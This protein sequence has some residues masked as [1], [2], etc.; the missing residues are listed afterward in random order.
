M[1][2]R[3]QALVPLVQGA[4]P[5]VAPGG[6]LARAVNPPPPE[7]VKPKRKLT[8]V[9][10]F[11]PVHGF[12]RHDPSNI[13]RQD[14]RYWVF[15]T[16][17]AGDH[18]DVTIHH[19]DSADGLNWRDLGLALGRGEP[20]QWDESGTIAPC[21]VP[22]AGRF[23]LFYTGFRGGDLATRDIGIAVAGHPS[24]PWRRHAA[25][26]VLRRDPDPAVWDSGMLGDANVLLRG[27]RWWL[28]FKGRRAGEGN[29]QTRVGVAS[30]DSPLGPFRR[31]PAN[32]LFPGH[33]FSAWV[34][35]DGVA[36]LCGVV[37][38]KVLWSEDGIAF[39]AVGELEN[40]STGLY[41]PGNFTG[42]A[43]NEGLAWGL[44][45]YAEGATRGLGRIDVDMRVAPG[46]P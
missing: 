46:G 1:L 44:E 41:A 27:G 22:H 7:L 29:L 10:A 20:G 31:H 15:Y 42:R 43:N 18:R 38:R 32:P 25:N 24:G 13:I 14:G 37:S 30:A 26:P 40:T 21:I 2:N 11:R 19:A 9:E 17:N 3:R 5:W 34:H 35:R 36:A 4:L 28:Y 45:Q 39:T 16:R 8:P 33:A 23:L 6:A 12:D